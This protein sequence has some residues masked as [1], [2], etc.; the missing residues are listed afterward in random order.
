M[1]ETER[2]RAEMQAW[3][4]FAIEAATIL[5]SPG[6]EDMAALTTTDDLPALLECLQGTLR[7]HGQAIQQLRVRIAELE[8]EKA[9]LCAMIDGALTDAEAMVATLGGGR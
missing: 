2:L 8:A 9:A 4:A 5:A 1:N 7:R 6:A 3:R